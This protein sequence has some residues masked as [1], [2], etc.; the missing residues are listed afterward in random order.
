[1]RTSVGAA[2]S[3]DSNSSLTANPNC[4]GSPC[5]IR[6]NRAEDRDRDRQRE[7][8]PADRDE[9]RPAPLLLART[10]LRLHARTVDE[11][12]QV[13]REDEREREADLYPEDG[14]ER[15]AALAPVVARELH[16]RQAGGEQC[17]VAERTPAEAERTHR[18]AARLAFEH[19][20][21]RHAGE[22]ERDRPAH[23]DH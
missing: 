14:A 8:R 3:S 21:R 17:A 20:D 13:R 9:R 1:A 5:K 18:A 10:D 19:S 16:A 22:D 7:A 12:V 23:P 6:Q 15:R 2:A 4:V 11:V